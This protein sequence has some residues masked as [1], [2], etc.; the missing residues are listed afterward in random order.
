MSASQYLVNAVLLQAALLKDISP[1]ILHPFLYII[2]L[3]FSTGVVPDRLKLK[4]ATVIPVFKT[5]DE[6]LPQN[7]GPISLL[8]VFHKMI[9]KLTATRL[10]KFVTATSVLSSLWIWTEAFNCFRTH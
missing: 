2:N 1:I 10:T 3:S 4:L 9:E 7:Y 6:T 8:S 5:R